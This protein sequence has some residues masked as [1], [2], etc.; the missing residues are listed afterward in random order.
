M[1]SEDI[2]MEYNRIS[3]DESQIVAKTQE[4]LLTAAHGKTN[5]FSDE[6]PLRLKIVCRLSERYRFFHP[7]LEFIEVFWLRDGFDII[8]GNPPWLKLEFDEQGI[9][10]EKYPEVA[11]RKVSAPEARK[12]RDQMFAQI[13]ST[14]ELYRSEEIETACSST[15]MNAYCNYP[16]LIGQQTNLYKCVLENGFSMMSDKGFMGLLHPETIYDDPKGQPLR[17]EVYPRL[18]YHFQYTNELTLFAEVDHHTKYGEQIYGGKQESIDF[19]SIH[20]LFHPSTIDA[21]FVHDGHGIC[22]G[23]KDDNG[24]WNVNAHKDRI[25]HFTETELRV[26]S[27]AFEDGADWK[28]VKLTSVHAKSLVS[29][30]S[31]ISLFESHVRYSNHYITRAIEETGG[32][33][34]GVI[35][36]FT[37]IPKYNKYEMIFSGP[38]IYVSNP[39]Y[40]TP[41][42][43]CTLNSDYDI[44]DLSSIDSE[45]TART[46]YVPCLPLNEYK[47]QIKANNT[48]AELDSLENLWIDK[49]RTAYRF[50]LNI[51]GERA[52]I[53]SIIPPRTSH[54]HGINSILFN[55]KWEQIEFSGLVSSLVLDYYVKSIGAGAL[56]QNIVA[57]FPLGIADKYKPA[58]FARTLMLNCLTPAYADLWQEMW[59]GAYKNETWSLRDKRLK[60]FDQLHE[61]WS[62]DIP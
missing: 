51:S 55:S 42:S 47:V 5:L 34:E 12:M 20:N 7:M 56:G 6:D 60:P 50:M 54:I 1:V 24:K 14:E 38:H 32:V 4:E 10:S 46:N 25:V 59:D 61:T 35:K 49:Y 2:D 11:I 53:S 29:T 57:S 36:R 22:G 3:E 33:N 16:L 26:L 48:D 18:R 13:P 37:C 62:W 30:L 43:K 40:K 28:S 27:E 21:C 23:I 39:V 9:L 8:C 15:F 58:L 17:K 41:R 19:L 31:R 52:L 45:H 44:I